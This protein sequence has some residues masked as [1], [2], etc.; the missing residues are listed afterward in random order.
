MKKREVITKNPLVYTFIFLFV[1]L[2][3]LGIFFSHLEAQNR[4]MKIRDD[5]TKVITDVKSS[6]EN[7]LYLNIHR[8]E[9]IRALVAMKPDLTQ[10]D[11]VRAMEMNFSGDHDLRNIGLA[12]GMTIKYVYPI[13]GNEAAIGLDFTKNKV[14]FITA[15]LARTKEKTVIAGPLNLVQGGVGIIARI[16]IYLDDKETNSHVFWGLA[17]VVINMDGFYEK[18]GLNDLPEGISLAI[19]GKDSLGSKGEIFFGDKKVFEEN[20]IIEKIELPYGSW[21]IAA[22]PN[23]GWS[24]SIVHMNT[25]ISL[26]LVIALMLLAANFV[27]IIF[28]D[29]LRLAEAEAKRSNKA[30][31]EFLANMSHEIRTPLNSVI[32]FT[33]LLKETNLTTLQEQYVDS[34][35]TSGRAL[36]GIINDILDFSKIEAGMMELDVSRTDLI[37]LLNESIDIVKYLAEEKGLK[38]IIKVEDS[39]PRFARFDSIRLKQILT[40]LLGNAVKFT[41]VGEVELSLKYEEISNEYGKFLFSV[42]DTGIG[43]SEHKKNKLFKAFSQADSSTTRKF[44]GTGLGLIISDMIAQMMKSKIKF[45]SVEGIGTTFYFEVET[46]IEEELEE[47]DEVLESDLKESKIVD[48]LEVK[49]ILVADDVKMNV[50]LIKSVI[51]KIRPNIEIFEATN[52]LNAIEVYKDNE[53]DLIFMDVQMPIMDGVE[54]TIN[55]RKIEVEIGRRV[56]IIALTAGVL[57]EEREKCLNSGM[58]DFVGKPFETSKIRE[59]LSKYL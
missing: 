22:I 1:G 19:R 53:I 27:M 59:I 37:E 34:A 11:F 55:I 44:G 13:K 48:I 20:P 35:N 36:L 46:H 5:V 4:D 10:E 51:S 38:L 16:P 45:E 23:T 56:P 40:N 41:E 12:E 58:D 30:K 50:K 52:G 33:N 25:A 49:R 15:D 3:V 43:I 54:A 8:T 29:R 42:R 6:I 39:V 9:G 18:S 28:Y 17:S 14:Q 2:V 32:G 24:K 7:R 47:I 31:S 26:Y 21:E 57:K